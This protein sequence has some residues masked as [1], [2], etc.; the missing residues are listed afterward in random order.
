MAALLPTAEFPTT[1]GMI[2]S[3]TVCMTCSKR[4]P[5]WPRQQH[6]NGCAPAYS[7]VSHHP[8]H[9]ML[10]YSVHDMQLKSVA[11]APCFGKG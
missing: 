6:L 7:W 8:W 9:N 1:P 2:C 4:G 3:S 10:K 11:K 5:G